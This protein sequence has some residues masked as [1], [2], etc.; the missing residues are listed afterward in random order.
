MRKKKLLDEQMA[1]STDFLKESQNYQQIHG[2]PTLTTALT[3][4]QINEVDPSTL[5]CYMS[6]ANPQSWLKRSHQEVLSPLIYSPS[7]YGGNK[8]S[9]SENNGEPQYVI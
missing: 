7:S 8:D 2:R 3:M 9:F 5:N 1:Q 6:R 4:S